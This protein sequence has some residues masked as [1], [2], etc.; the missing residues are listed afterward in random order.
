MLPEVLYNLKSSM[1]LR[2]AESR[3]KVEPLAAFDCYLEKMMRSLR[4]ILVKIQTPTAAQRML[5]PT[6]IKMC[7]EEISNESTPVM[8]CTEL[9]SGIK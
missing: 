3:S 9:Y 6:V 4:N 7:R 1:L 8:H 5:L 2:Y